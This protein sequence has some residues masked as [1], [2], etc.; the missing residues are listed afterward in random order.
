MEIW[1][2][3]DGYT[4]CN[5]KEDKECSDSVVLYN[6]GD[7]SEYVGWSSSVDC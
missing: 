5:E 7:H 4:V 3:D 6:N 2:T 1:Y